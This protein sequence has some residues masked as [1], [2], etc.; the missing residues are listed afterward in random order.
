MRIA[1]QPA[2]LFPVHL[3]DETAQRPRFALG[4][5]TDLRTEPGLADGAKLV[6]RDLGGTA[7]NVNGKTGPPAK[8]RNE[9]ELV[10][11]FPWEAGTLRLR[12]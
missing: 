8:G 2:R 4:E 12:T 1:G 11:E 10:H 9:N 3:G 5:R 7:A 6:D